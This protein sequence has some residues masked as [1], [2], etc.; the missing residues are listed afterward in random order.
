MAAYVAISSPS[1][2]AQSA[3]LQKMGA[4]S[5]QPVS[6]DGGPSASEATSRETINASNG[7]AT[8]SDS[9]LSS[10][11]RAEETGT[12]LPLRSSLSTNRPFKASIDNVPW[13]RSG[14]GALVIVLCVIAAAFF[15][16][17]RWVPSFRH[18]DSE[19]MKVWGRTALGPRHSL[20]LVQIGRRYVVVGLAGDRVQPVCEVSDPQESADLALRLGTKAGTASAFQSLLEMQSKD[21]SV[22]APDH[23]DGVKKDAL[24]DRG[25]SPRAVTELLRR[26]RV[27][28]A[29]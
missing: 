12:R 4:A 3:D 15:L 29:N 1:V 21:F 26:L 11:A 7:E 16:L 8:S 20:A 24:G 19:L 2:G 25:R 27:L 10:G 14:M 17:R 13:Y 22:T 5:N 23:E 28:Q 6:L 9:Q 18:S